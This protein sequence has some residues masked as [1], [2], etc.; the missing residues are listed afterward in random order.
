M[1]IFLVI[2]FVGVLGIILVLR[3][4]ERLLPDNKK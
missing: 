1:D 3:N 2:V 4:L